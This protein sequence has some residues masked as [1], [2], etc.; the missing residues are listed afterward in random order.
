[1]STMTSRTEA[2][3]RASAAP[4]QVRDIGS[5]HIGGQMVS[6]TGMAP[7]V[8]VSTAHGATHPIDPNG[9]MIVGQMYVQYVKLAD[10]AAGIRF[11]SGMAGE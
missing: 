10:P 6:L 9:E 5:F 1:M 11:C 3:L 2:R 8:R 7:R 4:L